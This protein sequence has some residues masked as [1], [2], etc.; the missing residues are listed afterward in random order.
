MSCEATITKEHKMKTYVDFDKA[1]EDFRDCGG[2]MNYCDG[3]WFI[4]TAQAIGEMTTS[5]AKYCTEYAL[6]MGGM[7]EGAIE[8]E[9]QDWVDPDSCGADAENDPEET[10]TEVEGDAIWAQ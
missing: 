9:L 5:S 1:L 8:R 3:L 6:T 4:G 2:A 10:L 7:S